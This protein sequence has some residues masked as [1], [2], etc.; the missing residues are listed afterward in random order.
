MVAFKQKLRGSGLFTGPLTKNTSHSGME[1]IKK[2]L[3]GQPQF[4]GKEEF[5]HFGNAVHEKFLLGQSSVALPEDQHKIVDTMVAKLHD[6]SVVQ[7]LLKNSIR[8][9]K[10]YARLNGIETAFILDVHQ[11][12]EKRGTDLKTT[13]SKTYLEFLNSC[14]SFGY[15]RQAVLYTIAARLKDFFFVGVQKEAPY[16]IYVLDVK[17]YPQELAYAEREL[18]FLLYFFKN[19]GTLNKKK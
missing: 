16:N 3:L 12:V 17:Q 10:L 18:E 6:H 11:K 8:E 4:H 15:F 9:Q 5:L 2:A 7:K 1:V 13:K 14:K 19:Y